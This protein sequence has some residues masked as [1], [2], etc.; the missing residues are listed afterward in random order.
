MDTQ[1]NH[2]TDNNVVDA[3]SHNITSVILP[4]TGIDY[5]AITWD[6][7]QG[8]ELQQYKISPSSLQFQALPLPS[9]CQVQL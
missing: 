3:L 4:H 6:Q 8:A 1:H 7:V 5:K 9:K 2:G